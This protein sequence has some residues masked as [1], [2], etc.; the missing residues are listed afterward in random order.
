[1]KSVV[2]EIFFLPCTPE[3][4]KG[5]KTVMAEA[6][7]ENKK[8]RGKKERKRCGEKERHEERKRE[9]RERMQR[10]N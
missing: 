9:P 2:I 8:R 6:K 7:E 3:R 4:E 5:E 1:M 10:Q